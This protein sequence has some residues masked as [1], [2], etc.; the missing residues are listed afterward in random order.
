MKGPI[1]PLRI[2]PQ[3]F[4]YIIITMVIFGS[5]LAVDSIGYIKAESTIPEEENDLF[6]KVTFSDY[7]IAQQER[8]LV[9]AVRDTISAKFYISHFFEFKSLG[10]HYK[11][12][13]SENNIHMTF[14]GEIVGIE[15]E[16]TLESLKI[17]LTDGTLQ[18]NKI[19]IRSDLA[20]LHN[21]KIG[22]KFA[23]VKTY[24]GSIK[25]ITISGFFLINFTSSLSNI[26]AIAPLDTIVNLAHMIAAT[27]G[28]SYNFVADI[29]NSL[30]VNK[31][32]P[33]LTKDEL[34]SLANHLS[35]LPDELSYPKYHVR[36][37]IDFPLLYH[38]EELLAWK[39]LFKQRL[40]LACIPLFIAFYT[41]QY[42]FIET[43]YLKWERELNVITAR[44]FSKRAKKYIFLNYL[45]VQIA[46]GILFGIL[47][48]I[49]ASR[50]FLMAYDPQGFY[51]YPVVL[52]SFMSYVYLLGIY[53]LTI[54]I[55]VFIYL[56]I[57][58][59]NTLISKT[60]EKKKGI[61]KRVFT[62][63]QGT[64]LDALLI[65]YT[66][67][68]VA[69]C[70]RFPLIVQMILD[71]DNIHRFGL[72]STL[73]I[74]T[75]F[76]MMFLIS[77]FTLVVGTTR[78]VYRYLE[79]LLLHLT[80]RF[81]KYNSLRSLTIGL[82]NVFHKATMTKVIAGVFA[83]IVMV[84]ISSN[85]LFNSYISSYYAKE[86]WLTGSDINIS[87]PSSNNL[88]R[89]NEIV[90]D[91][92]ENVSDIEAYTIITSLYDL[93]FDG[94]TIWSYPILGIIPESFLETVYSKDGQL[95][96]EKEYA[97]LFN[98]I[99]NGTGNGIASEYLKEIYN[100]EEGDVLKLL[101]NETKEV[102]PIK[103]IG[104]IDELL[105]PWFIFV[106]HVLPILRI[107]IHVDVSDW[108]YFFYYP[109]L[110]YIIT[111]ILTVLK[112]QDYV[113]V[114]LLIRLKESS[115]KTRASLEIKNRLALLKYKYSEIDLSFSRFTIDEIKHET[116][117]DVIRGTVIELNASYM[118]SIV[119]VTVALWELL[120]VI[121]K[122]R[123]REIAILLAI[124][125]KKRKIVELV[126][127]EI[128]L[129][130]LYAV[131]FGFIFSYV[132]T[133]IVSPILGIDLT[134]ISSVLA[135][136]ETFFNGILYSVFFLILSSIFGLIVSIS[137][138]KINLP[139]ALRIEWIP[140]KFLEELK[141]IT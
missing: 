41:I 81:R 130:L 133:F 98:N 91:I 30:I 3:L 88:T 50:L 28:Y 25:N 8:K 24:Y 116:E 38:V 47:A 119:L 34:S 124:G 95:M 33:E 64:Y 83:I 140:E 122:R 117:E 7:Q 49:G 17:K 51:K 31:E 71:V 57:K 92:I 67:A 111:D 120:I 40:I 26:V 79:P 12:P 16:S 105:S 13:A 94:K 126:F 102:V 103:I 141:I 104:T 55:S 139:E 27:S 96:K 106:A 89:I 15:N 123:N 61:T 97:K 37:F 42:F 112:L 66:L 14:D 62:V 87:F 53:L 9:I 35:N 137:S 44:G 118:A 114:T 134:F 100:F 113:G 63:L 60:I 18:E 129:T 76:G 121:G 115:N 19:C 2:S 131:L 20:K 1:N 11:L 56:L 86:Y 32:N 109:V 46:L 107:N 72:L 93:E 110:D 135:S 54:T 136:N 23:I 4:S 128:F 75:V 69:I 99:R 82:R 85:T 43:F 138:M 127:V 39:N 22:D 5:L 36:V 73:I 65:L 74:L 70:F 84:S 58:T 59:F 21:L 78:I 77:P 52:R 108:E 10:I 6:I 68:I 90:Q 125:E 29:D 80:R 48:G 45:S 101:S 132:L